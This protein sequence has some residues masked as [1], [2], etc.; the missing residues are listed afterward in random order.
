MI[1]ISL[2]SPKSGLSADEVEEFEKAL[3]KPKKRLQKD[4]PMRGSNPRPY[5]F[6]AEVLRV[7]RS[8]D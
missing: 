6:S 2:E 3:Q 1:C 7:V 8:T 4:N 5:D